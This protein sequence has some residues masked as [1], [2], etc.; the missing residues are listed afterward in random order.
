MTGSILKTVIVSWMRSRLIALRDIPLLNKGVRAGQTEPCVDRDS[1]AHGH[2]KG[3]EGA[4]EHVWFWG[5]SVVTRDW[6]ATLTDYPCS[7]R[8]YTFGRPRLPFSVPH[9]SAGCSRYIVLRK[10]VEPRFSAAA[11]IRNASVAVTT[12]CLRVPGARI[13]LV[14]SSTVTHSPGK[15]NER[16]KWSSQIRVEACLMFAQVTR[17]PFSGRT[18]DQSA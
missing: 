17:L 14:R 13:P 11:G 7:V 6:W 10:R 9:T 2:E 15:L 12:I 18:R 16:R 3:S 4:S 1:V 5:E 8:L